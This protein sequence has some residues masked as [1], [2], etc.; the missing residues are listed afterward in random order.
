M[1]ILFVE[2]DYLIRTLM[3]EWLRET[4][5]DVIEAATGD[6]AI[7]LIRN[8]PRPFTALVTDIHMPGDADGFQ[9]AGFMRHRWPLVPVIIATGRPDVLRPSPPD[10]AEAYVLLSKPYTPSQLE[11]LV[12]SLLN[13][14]SGG[15]LHRARPPSYHHPRRST[16]LGTQGRIVLPVLRPVAPQNEH[17]AR[18]SACSS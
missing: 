10:D 12:Q 7:E 8:P 17:A 11:G 6:E 4:G 2:D 15:S 3:V 13:R 16:H 1:C 18:F 14:P 5:H 9:V